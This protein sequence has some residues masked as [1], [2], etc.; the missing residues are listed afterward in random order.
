MVFDL[1]GRGGVDRYGMYRGDL[2]P[3]PTSTRGMAQFEGASSAGDDRWLSPDL[4]EFTGRSGAEDQTQLTAA[5]TAA[6]KTK[7]TYE[8]QIA[9]QNFDSYLIPSS[10]DVAACHR[11]V[12]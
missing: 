1:R 6:K 7:E 11:A 10:G 2:E 4:S 9:V 12:V 3:G 5:S 8:P